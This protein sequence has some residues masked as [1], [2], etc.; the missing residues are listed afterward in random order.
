MRYRPSVCCRGAART[1]LSKAGRRCCCR[2]RRYRRQ[3]RRH[4]GAPELDPAAVDQGALRRSAP[5]PWSFARL[6]ACLS[7]KPSPTFSSP[8]KAASRP[9]F[10][11][12]RCY[13]RCLSLPGSRPNPFLRPRPCPLCPGYYSRLYVARGNDAASAEGSG[14]SCA[15]SIAASIASAMPCRSIADFPAS[16][17]AVPAPKGVQAHLADVSSPP[18]W[19][20]FLPDTH[21]LR[22]AAVNWR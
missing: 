14:E 3:H 10:R 13:P 17:S 15:G 11:P 16:T 20:R 7:A 19:A 9:C 2:R 8:A 21:S 12:R 5:R 22:S 4:P 1:S 6:S 18:D